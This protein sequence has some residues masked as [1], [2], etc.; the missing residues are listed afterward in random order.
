MTST[1]YGLSHYIK[2]GLFYALV[3]FIVLVF[4][5]PFLWMVFSSLK[6]NVDLLHLPPHLFSMYTLDNYQS[7]FFETEFASRM[8]SSTI[9]SGGAVL[10]ALLLGLPA[11]YVIARYKYRNAALGILFTRMIP[12]ISLLVPWFIIYRNLNILDTYIGLIASHLVLTIPLVV[13]VMI[14]F[15]EDL[16]VELEESARIDGCGRWQAFYKI[17]LP[18]V[19]PGIATS[20]ILSFIFSW[21]HFLFAL[22]LSGS[23]TRTLPVTIF[24]FMTYEEIDFGGLYAA[25]TLI[26]LPVIIFVLLIQRQFISGLTMGGVKG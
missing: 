9:V 10:T 4:L 8:V 23:R 5:F 2:R 6:P 12:G 17:A 24:Q 22:I 13:W 3:I 19:R 21:N 15:F 7:V 20:A 25:A 14:G 16:P 1:N 26:T 11:S 18:L